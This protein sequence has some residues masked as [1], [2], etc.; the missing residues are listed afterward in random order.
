MVGIV[1]G[2][3]L[4]LSATLTGEVTISEGS[5]T[6]GGTD[7]CGKALLFGD[8]MGAGGA[9]C[10]V[11][12]GATEGGFVAVGG[13]EVGEIP[14]LG[15]VESLPLDVEGKRTLPAACA[16]WGVAIRVSKKMQAVRGK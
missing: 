6:A 10:G 16:I 15:A 4:A 3:N 14:R 13:E 8:A 5:F 9:A 7:V 2:G 12:T 1:P 11:T